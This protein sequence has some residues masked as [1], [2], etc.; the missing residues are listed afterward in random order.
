MLSN[1]RTF[2]WIGNLR[3]LPNLRDVTVYGRG[4]ASIRGALYISTVLCGLI[5]TII[6]L[7]NEYFTILTVIQ[8]N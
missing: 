3:S 6:Q 7:D 4:H 2:M 8:L 5:E 1:H